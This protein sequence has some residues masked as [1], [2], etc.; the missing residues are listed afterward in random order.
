YKRNTHNSKS[1]GVCIHMLG[2]NKRMITSRFEYVD[3]LIAILD[4]CQVD[5]ELDLSFN[6]PV[7]YFD[8]SKEENIKAKA[9]SR[10][11]DKDWTFQITANNKEEFLST[12]ANTLKDGDFCHYYIKVGNKEIGKGY[13][14]FGI[15]FLD[16]DYF[17]LTENTLLRL[18][19]SDIYL[20]KEI[21]K[22]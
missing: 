13:D 21:E 2:T 11:A 22:D 7:E 15:N 3:K 6:W 9:L 14:N 5:C 8:T 12:L 1:Q 10:F 16:P 18:G 19:D 17:K 4:A 20:K